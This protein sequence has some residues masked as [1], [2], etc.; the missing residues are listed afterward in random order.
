M[1]HGISPTRPHPGSDDIVSIE[2][3]RSPLVDSPMRGWVT[4]ALDGGQ[5]MR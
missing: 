2:C 4:D 5:Y 3:F 1:E